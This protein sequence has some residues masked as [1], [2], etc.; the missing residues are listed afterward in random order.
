MRVLLKDYNTIAQDELSVIATLTDVAIPVLS[1][2][3]LLDIKITKL[4]LIKLCSDVAE[5]S[6]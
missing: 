1:C 6:K 3:F 4:I 2:L 5:T